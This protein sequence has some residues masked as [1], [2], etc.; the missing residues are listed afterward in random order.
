VGDAITAID[1]E[2]VD[3]SNQLFALLE[4]HAVGDEVTVTVWRQGNTFDVKMPLIAQ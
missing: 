4:K 2:E 3:S 1:G